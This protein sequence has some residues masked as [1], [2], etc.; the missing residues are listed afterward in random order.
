VEGARDRR[1][2]ELWRPGEVVGEPLKG[3]EARCEVPKTEERA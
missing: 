3:E 2:F 1:E